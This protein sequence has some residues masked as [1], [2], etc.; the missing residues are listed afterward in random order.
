MN[1][2]RHVPDSREGWGQGSFHTKGT[3]EEKEPTSFVAG[4]GKCM[5]GNRDERG[6]VG[7]EG[8]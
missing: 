8:G 7:V 6:E 3:A 2:K 5:V 4:A 1:L